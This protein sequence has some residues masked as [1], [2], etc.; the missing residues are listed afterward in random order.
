[1]RAKA[2]AARFGYTQAL[3]AT[4]EANLPANQGPGQ[5]Q[6]EQD[7][8]ERNLKAVTFLT[9]AVP[10]SMLI[11]ITAAGSTDTNWPTQPKAHLMV[12][13]LNRSYQDTSALAGVGF[14]LDLEK[15]TMEKGDN[16]K[17]LFEKLVSVK[18]KHQNNPQATV[19]DND[20]ITQAIQALPPGY[21]ST[22]AALIQAERNAGRAVTLDALKQ[23]ANDYFIVLK[24]GKGEVAKAKEID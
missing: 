19:T 24:K 9:N 8:V 12:A 16:P 7:A 10:D 11:Q 17:F 22:V 1:M 3:S 21:T 23:A 2:Y 6:D 4:A 14:K 20:L 13:Y 5:N 15:C 18:F